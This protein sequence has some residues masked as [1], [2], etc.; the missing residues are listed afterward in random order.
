MK[1]ARAGVDECVCASVGESRDE[2][3]AE[4]AVGSVWLL[5]RAMP[6]VA[7]VLVLVLAVV[8]SAA[9]H[10]PP[11]KGK[12]DHVADALQINAK[13]LR[14]YAAR[15]DPP[16]DAPLPGP[17]TSH[18]MLIAASACTGSSWVH[19]AV[20]EMVL[21]HTATNTLTLLNGTH[22]EFLRPTYG[23]C[24]IKG[25]TRWRPSYLCGQEIPC[26]AA[27][28]WAHA[29]HR[30]KIGKRCD[31]AA[32]AARTRY[33]PKPYPNKPSAGLLY[34]GTDRNANIR[35]PTGVLF[36]AFKTHMLT[37][38][39]AD[40]ISPRNTRVVT[41]YRR[42]MLD[43][44]ICSM[45][46]CFEAGNVGYTTDGNGTPKKL[47]FGRR[48]APNSSISHDPNAADSVYKVFLHPDERLS[49]RLDHVRTRSMWWKQQRGH[50]GLHHFANNQQDVASVAYEDLTAFEYNGDTSSEAWATSQQAFVALLKSLGARADADTVRGVMLNRLMDRDRSTGDLI[51]RKHHSHAREIFNAP[52]VKAFLQTSEYRRLWRE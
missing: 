2:L 9:G 47:C 29:W 37:P 19:K 44:L 7:P 27:W 25:L 45:K 28:K 26:A 8:A 17:E 12:R 5:P 39:M 50:V 21:A 24:M 30:I 11:L 34:N 23:S 13:M 52:A 51:I 6:A 40:L 36:V 14:S 22:K 49:K 42:N 20:R 1:G 48:T 10:T 18:F 4:P 33:D 32:M 41:L 15:A 38:I 43:T 3:E 35:A 31:A 46:D 16:P